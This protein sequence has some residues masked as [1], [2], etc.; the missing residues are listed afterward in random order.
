MT[1]KNETR[2]QHTAPKP[3]ATSNDEHTKRREV[4]ALESASRWLKRRGASRENA[5][6]KRAYTA[7]AKAIHELARA[8]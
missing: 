8:S 4:R 7:A 6:T 1:T 5:T 2:R 3:K